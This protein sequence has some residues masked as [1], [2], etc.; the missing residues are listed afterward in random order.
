MSFAAERVFYQIYPLGLLGAEKTN[1]FE[2]PP[3][4]RIKNLDVF[5][6]HIKK[7][8]ASAIYFC[9]I[10]ESSSHGYD[11]ADFTKIDRRIGTNE[12]FAKFVGKAHKE[13]VKIVLDGVFNHVGRDFWAFKDVREKRYD[14]RYKDWFYINFGG[15]SNYGDGFWY[16]GWEGHFELVKLN[17]HN[18]EV[19]QHIFDS[20]AGWIEEFDI[21][22]LRLDVAY[23]LPLDFITELCALCRAK[24]EDF[25]MLGEVLHGDYNL[26]VCENRL[27]SVT[28]YECYKG[29]YSS[30]NESN[31]FE[32]GY[33]LNRQF[34]PETWT[35]Y[36]GKPLF[37]FVD[38][39]DVSRVASILNCE[40]DLPLIYALL[41]A[42]PGIP[43]V[44]YGSEW[45]EKGKKSDGDFALRPEVETPLWTGLCDYLAALSA[46]R[47]QSLALRKGSY[48]QCHL[49]NR[50]II[51]E[52]RYGDERILFALNIDDSEATI[53]FNANAGC[54]TDLITSTKIDFG[55]GLKIPAKTAFII[56]GMH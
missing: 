47:E 31:L 36:K 16:D 9:P 40:K 26:F 22:G 32:I 38:N 17:L 3:E 56:G 30:L 43:S 24:K 46:A 35:L 13:D 49:N 14:S 18:P 6:P 15:E 1:N 4:N 33:S 55:G 53:H 12:S 48:F 11:T 54:G 21:D 2:N 29:L 37:G 8:G 44:Y 39:H 19:R 34:G 23:S 10:F 5:L 20:V 51:F 41:F 28:N 7:L 42:M 52:R 27:E 50:Q 25:F 45:S